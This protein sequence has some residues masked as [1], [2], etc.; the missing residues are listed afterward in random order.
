MEKDSL[1]IYFSYFDDPSVLDRV[2]GMFLL[3]GG[4]F[5]IMGY[6]GTILMRDPTRAESKLLRVWSET[7]SKNEEDEEEIKVN[8]KEKVNLRN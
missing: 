5:L 8:K 2:P 7:S 3:L 6:T 4:I 1:S